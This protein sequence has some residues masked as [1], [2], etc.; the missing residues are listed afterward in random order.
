MKAQIKFI[1][2]AIALTPPILVICAYIVSCVNAGRALSL[3]DFSEGLLGHASNCGG[4]SAAGSNCRI[5][6]LAALV[7]GSDSND[8]VNFEHVSKDTQ[9]E[10]AHAESDFWTRGAKYLLRTG[11]IHTGHD[12]HAIVVVC[13]TPYGNV[14]QPSI[15]NLHRRT[16]RHAVGY[17]DGSIGWLTPAEFAELN[18]SNFF[19]IKSASESIKTATN[20]NSFE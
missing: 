13:D 8:V 10:L 3:D 14:P 6:A 12:T 7:E 15:W 19:E 17:S 4:N 16:L 20:S 1:G 2:I 18:K 5:I 9:N 11:T